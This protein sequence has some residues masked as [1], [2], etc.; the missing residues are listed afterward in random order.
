LALAIKLPGVLELVEKHFMQ[1]GNPFQKTSVSPFATPSDFPFTV[2]CDGCGRQIGVNAGM[3]G[4]EIVCQCG[5]TLR[6]PLLSDLRQ[7]KGKGA[8]GEAP[9]AAIK[10]MLATKASLP[11]DFCVGCRR[12]TTEKL[13]CLA[14][15]ENPQ[16]DRKNPLRHLLAIFYTPIW[17]FFEYFHKDRLMHGNEI[18]IHLPVT[19]CNQ[20][21]AAT[22]DLSR[23]WA[24]KKILQRVPVYAQLLE[25]YPRTKLTLAKEE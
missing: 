21:R 4:T 16:A 2:K 14:E 25:E 20:C 11:G 6:V 9:L 10:R 5:Q 7:M 19:F 13:V 17:L 15:C 3:A 8:Y 18:M 12:Q 24:L 23:A 22:K 1:E